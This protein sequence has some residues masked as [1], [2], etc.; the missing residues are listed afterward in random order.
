MI[1][2][3]D[4]KNNKY[5]EILPDTRY[6]MMLGYTS[7]YVANLEKYRNSIS[8]FKGKEKVY[9]V[10]NPYNFQIINQTEEKVIDIQTAF[11]NKYKVSFESQ[12]YYQ[13]F[14]V[15]KKFINKEDVFT[16]DEIVSKICNVIK[17]KNDGKPTK[18]SAVF[19]DNLMNDYFNVST[20][21]NDR[22]DKDGIFIM[23]VRSIL[24]NDIITFINALC[25]S[26][27][28]VSIYRPK[29][30]NIWLGNKYLIC[31]GFKDKVDI[32][33][34]V[35]IGVLDKITEVNNNLLT[36]QAL[37]IN[38]VV[39]YIEKRNYFSDEYMEY[40]EKQKHSHN[41]WIDEFIN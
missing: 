31:K 41:K 29:I 7:Y 25:N 28:E 35:D 3:S 32:I 1:S 33:N 38:K 6:K 14:E 24:S 18:H 2:I 26:F 39:D 5:I 12:K 4:S 15:I 16:N 10:L 23:K 11:K 34:K 22:L 27:K 20:L 30:T 21:I 36:E 13:V 37:N 17:I 40:F 19:I 9:K 8:Q